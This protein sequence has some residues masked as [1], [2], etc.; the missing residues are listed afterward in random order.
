MGWMNG[1]ESS[2]IGSTATTLL[3]NEWSERREC[4][5]DA[6][7]LTL[8][9]NN[10]PRRSANASAYWLVSGGVPY[11]D[12]SYL[13]ARSRAR[14][15]D[16]SNRPKIKT[17]YRIDSRHTTHPFPIGAPLSLSFSLCPYQS[18]SKRTCMHV[19]VSVRVCVCACR[20]F[21][22]LRTFG[23]SN[24]HIVITLFAC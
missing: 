21:W 17:A 9:W 14:A 8:L 16:S 10:L 23:I 12:I 15:S 19:C 6:R 13:E 24:H 20:C 2:R 11:K 5:V 1:N 7:R 4:Y 18:W 22:C 3:M